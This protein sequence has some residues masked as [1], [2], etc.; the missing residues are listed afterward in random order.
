MRELSLFTGAGGGLL[1]GKQVPSAM[2]AVVQMHTSMHVPTRM[3]GRLN[4]EQ[5]L[6]TVIPAITISVMYLVAIGN[7]AIMV[8]PYIAVHQPFGPCRSDIVANRV[9]PVAPTLKFLM[10][11]CDFFA[12]LPTSPRE[13]A[14]DRLIGYAVKFTNGPKRQPGLIQSVKGFCSLIAALCGHEIHLF[15]CGDPSYHERLAWI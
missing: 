6:N 10:M 14:V 15:V 12:H 5:I 2:R 13:H 4:Q 3:I 9:S 8:C 11:G 1:I 7:R